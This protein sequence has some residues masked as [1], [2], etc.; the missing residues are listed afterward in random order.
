MEFSL[1]TQFYISYGVFAGV[2]V[3]LVIWLIILCYSVEKMR[4]TSNGVTK[5]LQ[6][7]LKEIKTAKNDEAKPE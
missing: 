7:Q 1:Q 4:K 5:Q 2:T 6:T 3:I